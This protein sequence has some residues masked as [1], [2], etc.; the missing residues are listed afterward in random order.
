MAN[1]IDIKSLINNSS[2]V[3]TI[4][5][6]IEIKKSG[7][8]FFAKCP[9]HGE[10]T[11]SFYISDVSQRYYCFGCKKNGNVIDFLMEYNKCNFIQALEKLS[12]RSLEIKKKDKSSST[13]T[14]FFLKKLTDILKYN[15]IKKTYVAKFLKKRKIKY[16]SIL[17]FKIGFIPKKLLVFF[18]QK[19]Q[20]K[21]LFIFSKLGVFYKKDNYLHNKFRNRII[22]PIKNINGIVVAL[23]ARC[24]SSNIKPKYINSKESAIF[25]KKR[26]LYGL[27]EAKKNNKEDYLIIVEGYLDVITL[28]QNNIKNVSAIL[29]TA[30]S[31]EHILT[32]KSLY[33]NI[34]FCFDGDK[35]GKI[36][37]LRSAFICLPFILDFNS[38]K[39]MIMPD[40]MDPDTFLNKF[41]N[42][43][44]KSLLKKSV[45]ILDFI[46]LNL[47][48][49]FNKNFSL[50]NVLSKINKILLK[51]N[52]FLL[53]NLIINYVLNYYNL[54]KKIFLKK[55]ITTMGIK[56]CFFLLK[57]RSLISDINIQQLISNKKILFNSDIH[58]FF[59]LVFILK[60][61]IKFS[62]KE[63]NKRLIKKITIGNC[64][65]IK[66]LNKMPK[67]ILKSEFHSIMN[68]ITS[69]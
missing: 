35:A 6:F 67:K 46:I 29:G 8:G 7:S 33:K 4:S 19:S 53:K 12:N 58:L 15:I 20:K 38:I 28:H 1:L 51:L 66:L 41:G 47:K 18:N 9:F 65:F 32:I 43:S 23:G 31:K 56:A 30:I 26:I 54:K 39:F 14:D 57:D 25:S 34:I 40:K 48:G 11:A 3:S 42:L 52:N 50:I 49:N 44:F 36:A 37:S 59:D 63:I 2:I 27:Y 68:K 21:A 16:E 24:L 17:L 5:N 10:K 69:F 62:F 45:P 61:N 13:E 64:D 60:S 55:K 22:F